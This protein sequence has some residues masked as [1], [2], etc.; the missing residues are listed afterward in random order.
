M[1]V[2]PKK[3]EL[4]KKKLE[5]LYPKGTVEYSKKTRIVEA[6]AESNIPVTYWFFKMKDFKGPANLKV[7]TIKYMETLEDMYAEGRGLCFTGTY[8]IGK[9]SASCAILKRAVMRGHSAYYTTLTDIVNYMT[10]FAF[11]RE[12]YHTAT[13]SDFLCIDEVDSRHFSDSEDAQRMFGSNFERIVRY[14]IQNKLPTI[15]ASNNSTITEVF[16]GQYR[17][18]VDSLL[19][20]SLVVP[21]LG[22]DNRKTT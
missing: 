5:E 6:F 20:T 21:G 16:T 17:R 14:R 1:R 15:V 22:K 11:K 2:V 9:T 7:E 8:G 18:A 4:A 19:Q 10:D 3:L 13:R 12:F